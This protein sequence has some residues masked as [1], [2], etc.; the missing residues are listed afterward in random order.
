MAE[1][2]LCRTIRRRTSTAILLFQLVTELNMVEFVFMDSELAEM[3]PA[4]LAGRQMV[5]TTVNETTSNSRFRRSRTSIQETGAS[6][7]KTTSS[8]LSPSTRNYDRNL[9]L[10]RFFSTEIAESE[11]RT[12]SVATAVSATSVDTTPTCTRAHAH[13]SRAHITVHNS[14]TDPH[15][16]N[17]ST[18]HWLKAKGICVAH[19]PALISIS[20]LC[21][22]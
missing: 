15:F 19:F 7:L 16:S 11:F 1:D 17:V 3:A 4:Q 13:F 22:C 10:I 20:L 21:P 12:Q 6:R 5:R 9:G 8:T 14:Y 18:P 2:K